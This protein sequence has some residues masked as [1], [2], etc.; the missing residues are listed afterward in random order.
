MPFA[1]KLI[2]YHEGMNVVEDEKYYSQTI[3]T[4]TKKGFEKTIIV[5]DAN[6]P[7]EVDVSS[8]LKEAENKRKFIM[9]NFYK[10]FAF[11]RANMEFKIVEYPEYVEN[12]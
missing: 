11:V 9:R 6:F 5:A 1:I 3:T 8:T 10:G 7:E 12:D 2:K 4:L